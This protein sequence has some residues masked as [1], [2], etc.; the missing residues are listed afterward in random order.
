MCEWVYCFVWYILSQSVLTT[1]WL[2][3]QLSPLTLQ[4]TVDFRAAAQIISSPSVRET[5]SIR[6][7]NLWNTSAGNARIGHIRV[8]GQRILI[9]DYAGLVWFIIRTGKR[10]IEI[11][12]RRIGTRYIGDSLERF[13]T[14]QRQ[15]NKK[16]LSSTHLPTRRSQLDFYKK[17]WVYSPNK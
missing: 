16:N 10:I 3:Y 1:R 7:T 2:L 5:L 6:E 8:G 4:V 15:E 9:F 12:V 11:Y 13:T 14:L 17:S